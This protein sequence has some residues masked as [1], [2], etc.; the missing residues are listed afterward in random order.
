MQVQT[1]PSSCLVL[2][3]VT[4][5]LG[6]YCVSPARKWLLCFFNSAFSVSAANS[7]L[8]TG[9]ELSTNF[10]SFL[11]CPGTCTCH[12]CTHTHS[13]SHAPTPT[14][15]NLIPYLPYLLRGP[16]SLQISGDGKCSKCVLCLGSIPMPEMVPGHWC[17]SGQKRKEHPSN[18][19]PHLST[20]TGQSSPSWLHL[21]PHAGRATAAANAY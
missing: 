16:S 17:Q 18:N 5:A 14:P 2:R 4:E 11:N 8:G 21:E 9:Q 20:C 15:N 12:A 6:I 7:F 19:G 1:I 10:G 13:H 3:E